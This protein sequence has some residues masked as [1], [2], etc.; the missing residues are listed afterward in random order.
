VQSLVRSTIRKHNSEKKIN[1]EMLKTEATQHSVNQAER[2]KWT[3][4][5][6]NSFALMS[7]FIIGVL[8]KR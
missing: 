8:E 5:K 1:R 7:I 4:K 6:G 3:I 2:L